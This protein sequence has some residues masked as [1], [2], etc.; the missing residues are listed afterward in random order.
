[1]IF[2]L[3]KQSYRIWESDNPPLRILALPLKSCVIA[4]K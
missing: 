2:F 3:V 1:M 4:S